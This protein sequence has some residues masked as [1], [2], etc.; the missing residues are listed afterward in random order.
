MSLIGYCSCHLMNGNLSFVNDQFEICK[1]L[2]ENNLYN[3]DEPKY[4]SGSFFVKTVNSASAANEF[5][6][7]EKFIHDF[8]G[9]LYPD[10][11]EHYIIMALITLNIKRKNFDEALNYLSKAEAKELVQKINIK[12]YQIMIY[13]ELGYAEELYSFID[14]SKHFISNDV[15]SSEAVKKTFFNFISIVLKLTNLKSDISKKK[16]KYE[17]EKLKNEILLSESTNKIWL[18]EKIEDQL[19]VSS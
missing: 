8:R 2:I 11:K 12:R 7:A 16:H 19:T 15:K 14:T 13:Y 18:L 1:L 5:D 4:I 10:K 3:G 17:L 9:K 6:W